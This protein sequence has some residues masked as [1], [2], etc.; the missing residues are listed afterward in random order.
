MIAIY[1]YHYSVLPVSV[2]EVV[3]SMK[4]ELNFLQRDGRVHPFHKA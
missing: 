2:K 4:V 1:C 3:G